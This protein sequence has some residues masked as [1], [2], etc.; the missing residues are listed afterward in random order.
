MQCSEHL[1]LKT[2]VTRINGSLDV[3]PVFRAIAPGYV[4]SSLRD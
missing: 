2:N 3:A 1:K 4:L